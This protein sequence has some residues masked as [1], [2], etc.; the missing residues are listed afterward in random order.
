MSILIN[1]FLHNYS[2]IDSGFTTNDIIIIE[3]LFFRPSLF[4]DS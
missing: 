3:S 4:L 2:L 1:L